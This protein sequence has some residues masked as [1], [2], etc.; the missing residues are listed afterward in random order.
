MSFAGQVVFEDGK[1]NIHRGERI[2]LIGRNG[3]GKTT[4]LNLISGTLLPEA[5]TISV[6]KRYRIGSLPQRLQFREQSVLDEGRLALQSDQ[7]DE[8]WRVEKL[9]FGLGFTET[10]LKRPPEELSGGFQ[11]RLNLAKLLLKEPDL[12]LLDEPN[13]FLDI[14]AIRWLVRFLNAWKGELMLVT[15]DRGFMDMVVTHTMII[16]RKKIKKL[17]GGTE[18]LYRQILKEEEIHEKTRLNLEKRQK[19]TEQFITRFRAKARLA[20]LVQSRVKLLQKQ[21]PISRIE[22]L[23]S[24]DFSFTARPSPSKY[25]MHVEKL[26][27]SYGPAHPLL[28]D[29]FSMQIER[30]ARIGVIGKNGRGKTTLLR[31]LA[32]EIKPLSGELIRHPELSIGYFGQTNVQRLNEYR[33]IEQELFEADPEHSKKKVMDICGCLM[34]GSELAQKNISVLSGGERSRVLLGKL[35]LTPANLLLL[36]EP[37]NHLDMESCDSLMAAID[38]FP[39][40][41]LIV[42]HN[43]TF[44]HTLVQRLIVFDRGTLFIHNGSYA[45]FLEKGGWE[46]EGIQDQWTAHAQGSSS[47]SNQP[48][49]GELRRRRAEIVNQRSRSLRPLL[50]RISGIEDMIQST[51]EQLKNNNDNLVIASQGGDGEAIKRLS[52]QNYSL[53]L[54]VSSLY[55]ELEETLE[56]KERVEME[57][58]RMLKEII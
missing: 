51:E 28:I 30:D 4:L 54:L 23:K 56:E 39:G 32:G 25:L 18:K 21:Q 42:T 36:D 45:D 57:F 50:D 22:R 8:K 37:T 12:L 53:Q 58:S 43:E 13:N 38:S 2:G 47:S 3:S 7:K 6:P 33:S 5:G 41:V 49:R 9:L 52:K 10:D 15:H 19:E 34:F 55:T 46:S 44:L 48:D 1:F 27:F 26:S 20:G 24:I 17:G 16:H 31:L 14:L 29:G 35:L 40:A 11:V